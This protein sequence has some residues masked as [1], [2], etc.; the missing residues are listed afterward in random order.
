MLAVMPT[1]GRLV[2]MPC[3]AW[4]HDAPCRHASADCAC[5]FEHDAD[6]VC[7]A[8]KLTECAEDEYESEAPVF[9]P[10]G[11]GGHTLVS[12]DRVCSPYE[13]PEPFDATGLPA[14]NCA[15]GGAW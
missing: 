2:P 11:E 6:G 8:K 4:A 10:A 3:L 14:N 7:V 15:N 1:G 13:C 5:G 12:A 9:C